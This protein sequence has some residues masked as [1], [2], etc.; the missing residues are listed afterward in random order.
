MELSNLNFKVILDDKEF[1]ERIEKDLNAAKE[2]NTALSNLLDVKSKIF[3]NAKISIDTQTAVSSVET[4]K[5]KIES[6]NKVDLSKATQNISFKQQIYDAIAQ[7]RELEEEIEVIDSMLR[8]DPT[9][10]AGLINSLRDAEAKAKKVADIIEQLKRAE[11]TLNSQGSG[12]GRFRT[13]INSLTEQSLEYKKL[14]AYYKEEEEISREL[15]KQKEEEIGIRDRVAAAMRRMTDAGSAQ[16]NFSRYINNLTAPNRELQRMGEYYTQLEQ[17]LNKNKD[18]A[19]GYNIALNRQSGLLR[20]LA[21]YAATYFSVQ[22]AERL[23]SSLIRITGEFEMQATTLRSI[24]QD[25]DGADEIISKLRG[26]AVE[27][28]FQFKDLAT[29]AKQLSAYSVPM[30]EIYDTTKMLA[31]VSAGLGVGMD[32]LI[33]AYGQVRSA[34]FLRGQEVRQFTEAG[35]PV[36]DELSKQLTEIEGQFVS[37]GEVFDRISARQIPFEMISKMFKDMTSE[38]GK[39]FEMQEVQAETLSGK[40]SNLKDAYEIMMSKIGNTK[41]DTLKDAVDWVRSLMEN[42]QDVGKAIT[43]IV[44]GYGMYQTALSVVALATMNLSLANK[45]LIGSF[46]R[47]NTWILANPYTAL[48]AGLGVAVGVIVKAATT[49]D[50]FGKSVKATNKTVEE[51]NSNVASETS[52]VKYLVNRLGELT[53]GTQEYENVKKQIL[54]D[55]GHYLDDVDKEKLAIGEL[56]EVYKKLTESIRESAK[57]KAMQTGGEAIST[58]YTQEYNKIFRNLKQTLDEMKVVDKGVRLAISDYVRGTIEFKDLP[59]DAQKVINSIKEK[60]NTSIKTIGGQFGNGVQAN[61]IDIDYLKNNLAEAEQIADQARERLSTDLGF[62]YGVDALDNAQENLSKFAETVQNTLKGFDITQKEQARGLWADNKTNY[63]EYLDSIR[64]RYKEIDEQIKDLGTTQ[65]DR[66]PELERQKKIIEEI[67]KALGVSL[68]DKNDKKKAKSAAQEQIEA[69]IDSLKKLQEA[70][71]KLTPYLSGDA[72]RTTLTALFPNIDKNVIKNLDFRSQ[73]LE[74]G[75]KLAE[76]D[77]EA[78]KRL[79]AYVGGDKAT[80]LTNQFKALEAYKK[81]IDSWMGEDFNLSG[82]GVNFKISKIISD[83]NTEY[84]KITD[85]AINANKTLQKA[86]LGDEEA[87]AIV[88]KTYGEVF[89]QDYLINGKNVINELAEAEKEK[90]KE[91]ANEKIKSLASSWVKERM[92]TENID[93]SDFEQKTVQQIETLMDRLGEIRR[94]AVKTIEDL[95]QPTHEWTKD[96]WKIVEMTDEQKAKLALFEDILKQLDIKIEDTGEEWEKSVTKRISRDVDFLAKSFKSV[97]DELEEFGKMSDLS[98][99]EK[100]GKDLSNTASFAIDLKTRLIDLDKEIE[101]IDFEQEGWWGKMSDSAKG[102]FI[103]IAISAITFF[104]NK[105]KDVFTE[106]YEHQSLLIDATKEYG[107]ILL[108]IQRKS[109]SGIFG[110]D[111]LAL[112]AKNTEILFNAQEKYNNAIEA[113]SKKRWYQNYNK[114]SGWFDS[115]L[116]DILRD[117]AS[118]DHWELYR[119]NGELNI[120]AIK[121]YYESFAHNLNRRQKNLIEELINSYD[122]LDDAM[123][124]Q[125]EYWTDLFSGVADSIADSMVSAFAESGDAAID[126]GEILSNVS[127]QMASDLIKT[128]YLMPI[129]KQYESKIDELAKDTTISADK[130]AEEGLRFLNEAMESIKGQEP[131]IQQTL[132][133]IEEYLR[134][135]EEEGTEDLGNDIKGITETQANLMASYLNAIRADVSYGRMQRA[136]ISADLKLLLGLLPSSPTLA[137]YLTK[138]ESNTFNNMLAT[139]EIL[140]ELKSMITY[141]SGSASLRVYKDN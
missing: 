45:T 128:L 33:L 46:L 69:Q 37:V 98:G 74:L 86:L 59:E 119:E 61:V 40:I 60:V 9:S 25:I 56:S 122:A 8:E 94:E 101:G 22:G 67:V 19:E 136:E 70:Y 129:L 51:F 66:L 100:L 13:Y 34:A 53:K 87:L 12:N 139:T 10:F 41:M 96:G 38:G 124:Q 50:Q 95:K 126:M 137:E 47:L 39:F 48:A 55:Y 79:N 35:I 135:P 113:V 30:N 24:L 127:Q 5:E 90:A 123:E 78:A 63:T 28:P 75:K 83:L 49:Q 117:F 81:L 132:E 62:L 2:L 17:R 20:S 112:A 114:N 36:L 118:M 32:R 89:W 116:E 88:R 125:A 68:L 131:Y 1:N 71:E 93:L 54:K 64:K 97:G 105:L 27:S 92:E 11:N 111:E 31:D 85:K 130:K 84:G 134:L 58:A 107:D 82:T 42:F 141:D 120:E 21:G 77:P 65:Q 7:L 102:G 108:D 14:I 115:S 23:L 73:L 57:Q 138:I 133:N 110:A 121:A 18:A 106:A 52:K 4:L 104:Y 3:S 103:G 16:D 29:Y 80:E 99:L 76:F 44:V 140:S 109:F 72:M 43:G 91:T 26:L 15:A 6:I